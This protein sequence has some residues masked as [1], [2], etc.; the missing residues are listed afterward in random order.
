MSQVLTSLLQSV[1]SDATRQA[2]R[3]IV[4]QHNALANDVASLHNWS[5][6]LTVSLFA[7]LAVIVYLAVRTDRH[8]KQIKE[9]SA[10]VKRAH[11]DALPERVEAIEHNQFSVVSVIPGV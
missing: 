11:L 2:I 4:S 3:E 6:L 1:E 7:A 9:L 10:L 5:I 8:G